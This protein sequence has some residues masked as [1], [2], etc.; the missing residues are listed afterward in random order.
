M[1]FS[2]TVVNGHVRN[3]DTSWI[4]PGKTT[5]DDVIARLGRPPAVLGIKE[6]DERAEARDGLSRHYLECLAV[7]PP[8]IDVRDED[9][10]CGD[11][12][13]FRWFAVDSFNGKFEGGK[14]IVPTFAKGHVHRCH[15]V[16]I[17]F[18]RQD[19]VTLICRTAVADDKVRVLEWREAR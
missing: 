13:L 17:L 8:G 4:E 1:S 6:S 10:D 15:D 2:R 18:D 7:T 5:R 11:L 9:V 3:M 19:V 14:W 16:L 12:R